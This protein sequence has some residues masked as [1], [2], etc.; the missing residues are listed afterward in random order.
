M[1]GVTA[2]KH[3]SFLTPTSDGRAIMEFSSKELIKA[4]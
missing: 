2:G 3:D 4:A 1:T